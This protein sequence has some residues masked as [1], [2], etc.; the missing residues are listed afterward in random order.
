MLNSTLENF[1]KQFLNAHKQLFKSLTYNS[2]EDL[3]WHTWPV[4][5]GMLE[6]NI[7]DVSLTLHQ[8]VCSVMWIQ[9]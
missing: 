4:T 6:I 1:L 5:R 7:A 8:S 2:S 3:E 9:K